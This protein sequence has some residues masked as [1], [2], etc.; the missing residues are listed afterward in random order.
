MGES[1]VVRA[2]FSWF[3]TGY[4]AALSRFEPLAYDETVPPSETF[5]PLFETLNYAAAI[6]DQ[7]KKRGMPRPERLRA[8]VYA[9]NA[10]HHDWSAALVASPR[11]YGEATYGEA[12]YGGYV[13][14]WMP[15][16]KLGAL[17]PDKSAAQL[18]DEL[19]AGQSAL[20]HSAICARSCRATRCIVSTFE[21][22][23]LTVAPPRADR[24]ESAQGAPPTMSRAKFRP[25]AS[26]PF[27][28]L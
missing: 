14:R 18:Y 7:M 2:K 23:W 5:L 24:A 6:A 28:S 27:T 12:T 21:V 11:G 10:V 1:E 17:K 20:T 25:T 22:D 3:L 16:E 13:W 8:V 26:K 9:R 15:R 19:L 4:D